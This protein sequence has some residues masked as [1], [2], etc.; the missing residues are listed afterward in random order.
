MNFDR[1]AAIVLRQFYLYRSSFV[2]IMPL[3]VWVAIDIVLW[4]FITK[5][6][7][8]ITTPGINIVTGLL[9]AVLFWN[10]F[11]RVMNGVTMTFFEDVWSRN[12]L[13]MFSS[14]MTIPDYLAG[15]TLSSIGTSTIG[16]I[17]MVLVASLFF[18]FSFLLYGLV[19]I[20]FLLVLFLFA[21]A[22]GIFA[23]GLVLR[24]GPAAEWFVWPI[25]AFLS[26]F[27]CVFYPL[28]TLPAW[29]H[30]ISYLL[31]PT[32]VFENMRALGAGQ[33]VSYSDLAIGIALA[34]GFIGLACVYFNY[35]Y[36]HA[37]RTGLIAR[38]SAEAIS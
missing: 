10:F 29:T 13:N 5:Y 3:F 28:S 36:H 6:L 2:R 37:K 26:P 23:C 30:P 16:L 9:G 25:P 17:M 18:G 27:A 38:Y 20:P 1:V 7:G 21:V 12:F 19:A 11:I 22:L 4:G 35:I 24:F 15:L 34:F 31:P 8:A 32:Y 33:A 14:P